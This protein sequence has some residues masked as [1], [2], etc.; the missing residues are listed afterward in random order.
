MLTGGRVATYQAF[1][2]A[3]LQPKEKQSTALSLAVPYSDSKT[4]LGTHTRT[5][6]CFG[7]V[8]QSSAPD[9]LQ[10]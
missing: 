7:I 4:D 10:P 9:M 1:L 6:K 2:H 5:I 3:R 8:V